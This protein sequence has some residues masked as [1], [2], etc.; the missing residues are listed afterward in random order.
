VNRALVYK[1]AQFY[2][3]AV[4]VLL[5]TFALAVT[6]Y[7]TGAGLEGEI[8]R[9]LAFIPLCLYGVYVF[10]QSQD[11]ADHEGDPDAAATVDP[12]RQWLRLLAGLAVILVAVHF[13]VEAV[14]SVGTTLGVPEFTMGVTVLAGA[15]SVPD[16][17]VSV[18]AAR[19]DRAV[20]GLANVLGSNTF[21]LLVAIPVGIL[22][23]GALPIDLA[24]A[25]PMVAALTA[26]T[27][28]LFAVLRT[29]LSLTTP[30]SYAYLVAYVLFVTWVILEAGG[31][32]GILPR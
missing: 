3:L 19:A 29:D 14:A 27:V 23:A 15:T 4:S 5:T 31:V 30:E 9:P 7:P 24:M 10:I 13:L 12:G 6:Y 1:D 22:L 26:A 17:L 25:V 11:T 32:T 16:T 18:R 28:L 2:T 20:A 21:D 8:P